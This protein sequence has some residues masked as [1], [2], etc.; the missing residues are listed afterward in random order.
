MPLLKMPDYLFKEMS[1]IFHLYSITFLYIPIILEL[2]N[3]T[4][5]PNVKYN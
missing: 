2:P 1:R 4:S 5:S 3:L